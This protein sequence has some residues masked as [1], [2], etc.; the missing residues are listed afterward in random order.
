MTGRPT[1]KMTSLKS[2][3]NLDVPFT[4]VYRYDVALEDI[5]NLRVAV[6]HD[7]HRCMVHSPDGQKHV[8]LHD[9]RHTLSPDRYSDITRKYRAL[10]YHGTFNLR[11][12]SKSRPAQTLAHELVWKW[13]EST[14]KYVGCPFWTE[15]ARTLF[16]SHVKNHGPIS[17]KMAIIAANNI[18]GTKDDRSARIADDRKITHEHVFPIKNILM[19]LDSMKNP[20]VAD[21]RKL[22]ERLCVSC[23]VL[24][25]EHRLLQLPNSENPWYRYRGIAL[26]ENPHWPDE[27]KHLVKQAGL[28]VVLSS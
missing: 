12:K 24:E 8:C 19:V 20:S 18:S 9:T 5:E 17:L 2:K 28:K 15:K 10:L 16:D 7:L 21:I 11:P 25:S 23:V 6:V 27:H 26:I 22:L 4:N 3:L 14:G 1:G 13:T